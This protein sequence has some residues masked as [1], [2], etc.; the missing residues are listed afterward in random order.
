MILSAG[1]FGISAPFIVWDDVRSPPKLPEPTWNDDLPWEK[2][3]DICRFLPINLEGA[4]LLLGQFRA[5]ALV[6]CGYCKDQVYVIR[7]IKKVFKIR[8]AL[9]QRLLTFSHNQ[10]S[11]PLVEHVHDSLLREECALHFSW[12]LSD[13]HKKCAKIQKLSSFRNSLSTWVSIVKYGSEVIHLSRN[14]R[15]QLDVL[16]A[17]QEMTHVHVETYE[18]NDYGS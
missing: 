17:V 11:W 9:F 15:E 14:G 3:P 8:R 5:A 16:L 6:V 13:A 2:V 4:N 1:R 12:G 18:D 7:Q 10:R